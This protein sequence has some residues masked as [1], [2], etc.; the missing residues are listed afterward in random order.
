MTRQ[1]AYRA[2]ATP[3]MTARPSIDAGESRLEAPFETG[4]PAMR[5]PRVA[6]LFGDLDNR[7]SAAIMITL[8][9][10]EEHAENLEQEIKVLQEESKSLYVFGTCIWIYVFIFVFRTYMFIWI[11]VYI[12]L[13]GTNIFIF[14]YVVILIR[15]Y[16][17]FHF[18][19]FPNI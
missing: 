10:I 8:K 15:D 5:P 6:Q 14:G 2:V 16:E 1:F 18:Y 7:V 19:F 3:D 13:F 11:Y 17:F 12:Y 4:A 9:P